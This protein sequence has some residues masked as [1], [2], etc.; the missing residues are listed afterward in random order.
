ML[1]DILI[2]IGLALLALMFLSMAVITI[3]VVVREGM[4][5]RR[6]KHGVTERNNRR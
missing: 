1:I 4:A 3:I 6:E 5:E 2:K